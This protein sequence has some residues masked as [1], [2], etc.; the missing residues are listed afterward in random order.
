MWSIYVM[1]CYSAIRKHD[2]PTFA[3]TSVELEE[4]ALREISRER[5]FLYGFTYCG[6]KVIAGRIRRRKG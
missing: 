5:Q 3:S 6:T 1:E 4:I 2:Y